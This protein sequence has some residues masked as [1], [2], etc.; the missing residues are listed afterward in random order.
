[1]SECRA[2]RSL[3]DA[4]AFVDAQAAVDYHLW[5]EALNEPC[6]CGKV[7]VA[8]APSLPS[9]DEFTGAAAKLAAHDEYAKAALR[10]LIDWLRDDPDTLL[11]MARGRHAEGHYRY[12]DTLM[13][14]YG[15][16]ELVAEA[17]QEVA[18]AICYL[19][20]MLQRKP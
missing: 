3:R 13:F 14:E 20:L 17:A 1:V 6:K 12:G 19:A 16:D 18:D 7:V 2:K 8:A 9:A 4:M 5:H 10:Y 15:Q 11:A